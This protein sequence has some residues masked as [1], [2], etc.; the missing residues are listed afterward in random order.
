MNNALGRIMDYSIDEYGRLVLALDD[1]DR[2]ILNNECQDHQ[3]KL[4]YI[5]D[6]VSDAMIATGPFEFISPA[7]CG[8]LTDA[9]MLAVLGEDHGYDGPAF[10]SPA[11]TTGG[12]GSSYIRTSPGRAAKCLARWAYMNYQVR[13]WREELI[14]TGHCVWECGCVDCE[15]DAAALRSLLCID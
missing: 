12:V 4:D 14:E 10:S 1:Q 2:F 6:A 7:V 11:D 5:E 13:N 3:A 15:N 9:D 8:D